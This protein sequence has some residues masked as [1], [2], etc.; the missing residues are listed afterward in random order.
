MQDTKCE[1]DKKDDDD[2]HRTPP[3]GN[4]SG[5]PDRSADPENKETSDH[6]CNLC[7]GVYQISPGCIPAE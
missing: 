4:G 2:S 6:R 7:T 3:S 1:P 5:D